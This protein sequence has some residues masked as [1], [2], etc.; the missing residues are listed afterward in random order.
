MRSYCKHVDITEAA[1]C[2]KAVLPFVKGKRHR[3]D[4]GN[5]LK[6]YGDE[7]GVAEHVAACIRERRVELQPIHYFHRTE[8][9]NGK[10]REIG[11]ESA[12]HQ[13]YDYVAV[14]G[15]ME[16]FRAKVGFWQTASIPGRG[17]IY[18]QRGIK[19]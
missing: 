8:P 19:K 9:T 11:K 16:L 12:L 10:V 15:L 18:A 17:P 6:R 1:F 3:H 14:N 7:K 2:E 5:M 13:V 4:V